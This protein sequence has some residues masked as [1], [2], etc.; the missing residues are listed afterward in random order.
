MDIH[1]NLI[2]YNGYGWGSVTRQS[3]SEAIKS[4]GMSDTVSNFV[5]RENISDLSLGYHVSMQDLSGDRQVEFQNNTYYQS[6]GYPWMIIGGQRYS[7]DS[8][9]DAKRISTTLL[10]E[11][12]P[13]IYERHLENSGK[14]TGNS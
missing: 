10:E 9:D 2:R 8:V 3:T 14:M 12:N 4:C 11:L 6:V 13:T 7:F 5:I 1:H